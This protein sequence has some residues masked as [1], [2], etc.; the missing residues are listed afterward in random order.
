M[1]ERPYS[2]VVP[3]GD[4]GHMIYSASIFLYQQ[5]NLNDTA[6][7]LPGI[8]FDITKLKIDDTLI[9]IARSYLDI[10]YHKYLDTVVAL[11]LWS[12]DPN[13]EASFTVVPDS[14]T[15]LHVIRAASDILRVGKIP[16]IISYPNK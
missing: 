1:H 16:I 11:I 12:Y 6:I 8:A 5:T 14:D 7:K 3:V 2:I 10:D 4:I 9:E 13:I 15:A